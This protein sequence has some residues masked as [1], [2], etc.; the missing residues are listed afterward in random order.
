M[1]FGNLSPAPPASASASAASTSAWCLSASSL[2]SQLAAVLWSFLSINLSAT[3]PFR[4]VA[5]IGVARGDR[6]PHEQAS[7]P[8]SVRCPLF[9]SS[10]VIH[11]TAPQSPGRGGAIITNARS[12]LTARAN[13]SRIGM[14]A[15]IDGV[16]GQR[17]P[18]ITS[19]LT[20]ALTQDPHQ[21]PLRI[22]RQISPG[23]TECISLDL[24]ST[25]SSIPSSPD[26]PFPIS[27]LPVPPAC[28]VWCRCRYCVGVVWC[29][30]GTD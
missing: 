25:F 3:R 12:H 19:G 9:N 24:A 30:V 13:A 16:H 10:N 17:H 27:Q 1:H 8:L 7:A 22:L 2:L 28:V 20:L 23:Q 11:L 6:Y 29:G 18:D 21:T 5:L 26:P 4:S 15:A 14:N